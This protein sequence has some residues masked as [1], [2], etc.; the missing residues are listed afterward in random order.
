[1][2]IVLEA[3][4]NITLKVGGSFVTVGPEGVSIS[5]PMVNIN[6]GGSAGSGS[7]CSPDAPK[8]PKEAAD[9]KEGS[10]DGVPAAAPATPAGYG[11]SATVLK[12]AAQNGTP[13]CEQCAAAAA[14]Q[15]AGSSSTGSSAGS[16]S[17]A[18]T[19]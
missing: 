13:F 2:N 10:V 6:S 5:G 4:T 17:A 7:G 18:P 16:S 1:M 9:D 11:P 8:V 14:A 19:A 12:M 15:A 3:S